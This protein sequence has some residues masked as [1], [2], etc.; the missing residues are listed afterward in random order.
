MRFDWKTIGGDA[1]KLAA[2]EPRHKFTVP[3]V[4]TT[5][6]RGE[7]KKRSVCPLTEKGIVCSESC[8]GMRSWHA[9]SRQMQEVTTYKMN[10]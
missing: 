3:K 9:G 5:D 8:L 10:L 4:G 2:P 6:W 1:K 7:C